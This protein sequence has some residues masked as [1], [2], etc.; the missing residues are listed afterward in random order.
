MKSLNREGGGKNTLILWC[1][2]GIYC[3]VYI[4]YNV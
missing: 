1:H 3:F 2:N 4:I